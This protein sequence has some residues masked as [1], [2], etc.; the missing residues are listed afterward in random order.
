MTGFITKMLLA[1]NSVLRC[2]A[3]FCNYDLRFSSPPE[4]TESLLEINFTSS[5]KLSS[6]FARYTSG[7]LDC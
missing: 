4:V 7:Q 5:V 6:N 2:E 3:K 1:I